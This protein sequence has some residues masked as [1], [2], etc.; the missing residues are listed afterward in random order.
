MA[1]EEI[2]ERALAAYPKEGGV[3]MTAFGK[4]E[5]DNNAPKREGYIKALTE[6]NSLPKIRGYVARDEDGTLHFF[7]S[8]CGDG[9]P[10]F[11][12]ESGTWGIA[13]MEM[14]E[15]VHPNGEFGEL[16]FK[17]DP[18]EVELLIKKV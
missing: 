4:F 15:I 10:I 2:N 8:E 11:D 5:Y 1:Q 13:T 12:T 16:S 18:I 9:E 6:I 14:L 7:S 17:D 3:A